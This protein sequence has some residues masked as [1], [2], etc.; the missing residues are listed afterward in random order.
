MATGYRARVCGGCAAG[1][2]RRVCCP[3]AG[4]EVLGVTCHTPSLLCVEGEERGAGIRGFLGSVVG[5]NP[6]FG[7]PRPHQPPPDPTQRGSDAVC[8]YSAMVMGRP[9]PVGAPA[10]ACAVRRG[11]LLEEGPLKPFSGRLETSPFLDHKIGLSLS[12]SRV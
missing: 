7:A 2:P 11:R 8:W 3:L 9:D 5:P 12:I 4:S 1:S 10:V 6:R